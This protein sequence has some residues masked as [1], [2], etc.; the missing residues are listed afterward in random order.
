[1]SKKVT[2][3]TGITG[4]DGS[5]LAELLL[6]DGY[7]VHGFVR[8]VAAEHD[9]ARLSRINHI[10]GEV[11]LHTGSLE[12]YA[13][14]LRVVDRVQPGELYHLAAQSFVAASFEDPFSTM[15]QNVSGTHHVFEAVRECCDSCRVYFA[16]T[17]EM[18]GNS[19]GDMQD[20]L[21][22]LSPRSPYGTSKVAGYN[23]AHN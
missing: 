1:M 7:S 18:F 10:L 19:H 6:E 9:A 20:E 4:Q 23:L 3:I 14:V 12:N 15:Q 22:P 17:S 16:G 8:P 21:T 5:Y 11:T 13:S 2:L